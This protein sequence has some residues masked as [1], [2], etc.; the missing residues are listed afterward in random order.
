MNDLEKPEGEERECDSKNW[1]VELFELPPSVGGMLILDFCDKAETFR[2]VNNERVR[3][4]PALTG[5]V[6]ELK[7]R[8]RAKLDF[9]LAERV[10]LEQLLNFPFISD[11]DCIASG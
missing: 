3:L 9:G 6:D 5:S 1:L 8:A 11:T 7:P 4:T 10:Q 2:S